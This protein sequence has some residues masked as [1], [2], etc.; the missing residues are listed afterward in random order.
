VKP[1]L[2][3]VLEVRIEE[4]RRGRR[5]ETAGGGAGCGAEEALE[6][7]GGPDDRAPLVSLWCLKEKERQRELGRWGAGRADAG[8]LRARGKGRWPGSLRGLKE[9][10]ERLGQLGRKKRGEGDTAFFFF[11]N[12]FQIR[13]SNF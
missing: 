7:G 4:G 3:C 8:R 11:L 2:N 13:F 12:S 10:K 9:K 6:V 5:G 1:R